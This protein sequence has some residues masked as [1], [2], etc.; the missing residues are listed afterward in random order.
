LP[1]TEKVEFKTL[2]QHGNRFQIPRAIRWQFKLEPEQVLKVRTYRMQDLSGNWEEFYAQMTKDGR[3][4]VPIL[5]RSL[6]LRRQSERM[7]LAGSLIQVI[8]E[9]AGK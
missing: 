7:P 8:L 6:L 2:V 1:L 3:I 4:T 9:P 5:T